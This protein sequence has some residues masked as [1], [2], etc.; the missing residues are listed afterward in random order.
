[1]D[2]LNLKFSKYNA[3]YHGDMQQDSSECHFVVHGYHGDISDP[4][5]THTPSSCFMHASPSHYHQ[6]AYILTCI[7]HIEYGERFQR[8]T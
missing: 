6:H 7:E 1:M 3:F 4:L 5:L 8:R 2:E